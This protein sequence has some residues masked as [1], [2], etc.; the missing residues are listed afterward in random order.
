MTAPLPKKVLHDSTSL[1]NFLK[2][3]G[4]PEDA[5]NALKEEGVTGMTLPDI[6][7][8]DLKE[9]N[10]KLGPRKRIM[11][12]VK[13]IECQSVQPVTFYVI[14]REE[15]ISTE[16][17]EDASVTSS[18]DIQIEQICSDTVAVHNQCASHEHSFDIR[19]WVSSHPKGKHLC[20]NLDK[21]FYKTEDRQLLVRIV[22][23]KF[24]KLCGTVYPSA[25][26]KERTA[27]AI[28][29]A[30]PLLKSKKFPHGYESFYNKT[31]GTGFI[32]YRLKTIRKSLS[33]LQ[34]MRFPKKK[35]ARNSK[36]SKRQITIKTELLTKEDLEEK[37]MWM[38]L[39][40]P[41]ERNKRAISD[42]LSETMADRQAEI[43]DS[44]MSIA[45]ILERYPRLQDYRGDMI[46]A[47]FLRM[48]PTSDTFLGKFSSFY[49][50][51]ILKYVETRRPD[52]LV[53]TVANFSDDLKALVL[54]PEL[55]PSPNY[56]KGKEKK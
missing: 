21:G 7:E 1:A 43:K 54:L 53:P 48:H 25:E 37:I 38:R 51:R 45:D 11:Q 6:T 35:L 31:T 24:L 34:R 56:G 49:V 17:V 3:Q 46:D 27:E 4:V 14:P 16:D 44:A 55:L 36:V 13:G 47:E 12:I 9:M 23:S 2:L 5:A 40:N 19:H 39:K 42:V 41:T 50:P 28:V 30:F 8:E 32:E 18:Q 33:P 20:D 15:I 10:M 29:N 52:L 26:C 22:C